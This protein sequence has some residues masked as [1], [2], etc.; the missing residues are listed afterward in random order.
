MSLCETSQRADPNRPSGP[1]VYDYLTGGTSWFPADKAHAENLIAADPA[2][3]P[4]FREL[5]RQNRRFIL[6]ATTWAA[7]RGIRQ[8][9]DLGSGLPVTPA[10]H[11]A[12]P[13]A[14]VCYLDND[15]VVQ[16]KLKAQYGGARGIAVAGADARKPR[17]VLGHPAVQG[18]LDLRKP[19]CLLFG[20]TLSGMTGDEARWAVAGLAWVLAEGSCAAISCVS[21]A[22][23]GT[24]EKMAAALSQAG[25]W[26][27]H[28]EEDVRS[29]F[30]AG[31]L[32]V[33]GGIAGLKLW[34]RLLPVAAKGVRLIG[35][36]AL[37]KA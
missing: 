28:S 16:L 17:E 19:A 30:E 15:P 22:D 5:A 34:P 2:M 14:G 23:A 12:A 4:G 6:A 7:S 25:P 31:R 18:L 35:G 24:G 8:F 13:D 37:K 36:V 29:F 21:F 1:R 26:H 32:N 33:A 9:L 27:N 20:G 3:K 10:I 11:D